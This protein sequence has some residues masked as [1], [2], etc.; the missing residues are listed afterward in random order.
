M[1]QAPKRE[2]NLLDSTLIVVGSM[3]G[4]GIFIVTAEVARN[5]G[6]AGWVLTL[7][8]ATGIMTLIGALSYGELAGMMP[9]VGDSLSI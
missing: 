8:I 6:G 2:L 5:V 7:W 4:S 1:S 3:I 9:K